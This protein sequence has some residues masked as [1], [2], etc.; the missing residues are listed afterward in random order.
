MFDKQKEQHSDG[1][2]VGDGRSDFTQT[3]EEYQ[4]NIEGRPFTLIDV[5]GIEGDEKPFV[6]G[7]K[8]ALSKAHLVFYVQ[9]H[10][11]KPDVATA[12]KIK[13]YLGDWVNVYSIYN[14]RGGSFNYRNEQ[15]RETLIQGECGKSEELIKETFQEIL[16]DVYKGNISLQALLALCS[17]A[18]FSPERV[19]LKNTQS[20]L[21]GQ[22]G[23]KESLFSFSSFTAISNLIKKKS[24]NFREEI[25][26][27]NKQKLVSLERSV[28]VSIKD[29]M[30]QQSEITDKFS[31]VLNQYK[32]DCFIVLDESKTSIKRGLLAENEMLFST[33]KQNLF[34]V[35]DESSSNIEVKEESE[36][37]LNSFSNDYPIVIKK[38]VNDELS[39]MNNKLKAK[40]RRLNCFR[41]MDDNKEFDHILPDVNLDF[42]SALSEMSVTFGDFLSTIGSTASAAIVGLILGGGIMSIPFAILGAA[43]DLGRKWLFGDGGKGKAKAELE[44]EISKIKKSSEEK[45]QDVCQSLNETLNAFQGDISDKID[46]DLSGL[47]TI[48]SQ[49][50]DIEDI[51]RKKINEINNK[52]YG[53]I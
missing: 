8:N 19:D 7:I 5:P 34:D 3:Y 28:I 43:L 50:V 29:E 21:L 24:N 12:K 15:Q 51:I 40:Q 39:R 30:K 1:L 13:E 38:V 4:L 14:V 47:S 36:K 35:I 20:K 37:C 17:V 44:K 31:A 42:S 33:L 45:L 41:E 48:K 32:K 16:G 2:I 22:F 6:D 53:E 49:L 52:D 11:K 9:G 10:N 23:S 25:V 18:D 46:G 27:A 26:E